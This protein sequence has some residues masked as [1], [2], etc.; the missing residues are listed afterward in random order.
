M[1]H[2]LNAYSCENCGHTEFSS[3]GNPLYGFEDGLLNM[4]VCADCLKE[5]EEEKEQPEKENEE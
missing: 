3:V 4:T 1:T 5:L 2:P